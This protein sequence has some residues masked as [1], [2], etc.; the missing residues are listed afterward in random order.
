[1]T[2]ETTPHDIN[3]T[4]CPDG[5]ATGR[6][7]VGATPVLAGITESVGQS[8][9]EAF[10]Q[11]LDC[12]HSNHCAGTADTDCFCGIGVDPNNCF[13]TGTFASAT[14][15]CKNIVAVGAES[16]AIGDINNHF[17]D[18]TY[19]IGAAAAVIETCDQFACVAECL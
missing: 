6:A 17:F 16:T 9:A 15:P 5:T 14:G 19:A 2:C 10:Q 3:G 13:S 18:P 4:S 1:V 7:L 8:R 11:I 12:F